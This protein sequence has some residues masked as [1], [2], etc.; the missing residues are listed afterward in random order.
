MLVSCPPMRDVGVQEAEALIQLRL[1]A[2]T[3]AEEKALA[4]ALKAIK[5]KTP[6]GAL[7]MCE[8]EE[9][10]CAIRSVAQRGLAHCRKDG[11]LLVNGDL[12][13]LKEWMEREKKWREAVSR[14]AVLEGAKSLGAEYM[15]VGPTEGYDA[16]PEG[17][18]PKPAEVIFEN[19]YWRVIRLRR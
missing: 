13:G 3:P 9:A 18:L 17:A 5:E 8:N 2:E 12:V 14:G 10:A 15:L 11:S 16:R 4:E 1:T 6:E 7:F 19:E